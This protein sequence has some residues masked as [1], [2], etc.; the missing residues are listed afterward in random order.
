MSQQSSTTN[1]PITQNVWN[2][3]PP[4]SPS[5]INEA[6]FPTPSVAAKLAREE[7]RARATSQ[8]E[9][10]ALA[11]A[12]M[13]GG[14]TKATTSDSAG[15]A[16]P[17]PISM[18]P[19]KQAQMAEPVSAP[20]PESGEGSDGKSEG[21]CPLASDMNDSLFSP[22][23]KSTKARTAGDEQG[24]AAILG[25]GITPSE[26]RFEVLGQLE[27][28]PDNNTGRAQPQTKSS[29]DCQTKAPKAPKPRKVAKKGKALLSETD[30]R[31][32]ESSGVGPFTPAQKAR[33]TG[34][35]YNGRDSPLAG[36]RARGRQDRRMSGRQNETSGILGEDPEWREVDDLEGLD[37]S[38]LDAAASAMETRTPLAA[39]EPT[40]EAE[41]RGSPPI[42][43][44]TF[45]SLPL[46]IA[47]AAEP[48]PTPNSTVH[49]TPEMRAG[50]TQTAQ[51]HTPKSELEVDRSVSAAMTVDDEGPQV[52]T[53][54]VPPHEPIT[55]KIKEL[56]FSFPADDFEPSRGNDP[57]YAYDNL[58]NEQME[59]WPETEGYSFLV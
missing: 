8:R 49:A 22:V 14:K 57:C 59:G 4:H 52:I 5:H 37:I 46:D 44:P 23:S 3:T 40:P 2:K 9:R 47:A 29:A 42:P 15:Q 11:E 38:F 55:T 18:M 53:Q 48:R 17:T 54:P 7:K 25:G 32:V 1:A 41:P 51:V 56:E 12:A 26:N 31:R 34:I 27:H 36:H 6:E 21:G 33:R 45:Q 24:S 50:D 13:T 16:L 20:E 35:P 43:P 28:T 30:K 19:H 10:K 39:I 58:N